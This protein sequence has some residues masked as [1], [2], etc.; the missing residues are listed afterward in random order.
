M[1]LIKNDP[2]V[3]RAL[4]AGRRA[5]R[6]DLRRRRAEATLPRAGQR[7]QAVAA[8]AGGD[9]VRPGRHV[10]PLQARELSQWRGARREGDGRR[11]PAATIRGRGL[12]AFTSH[13]NGMP[14]NWHNQGA[15]AGLYDNGDIHAVRILAMEPT[16][17]RKRRRTSGRLF[18]SHASERLRILGEIPRAQVRSGRRQAAARSRRQ[19]RHQLPGQD[20][21]RRGVHVSDARQARHGAEHGAD[22]A[23]ASARRDSRTTA[24]AA[25][26]TARSRRDFAL[27]R[28]REARLSR[29]GI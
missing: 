25:T 26:P 13:G 27:T 3:Q 8:P 11:S 4:A 21:G 16:T 22:L 9:A 29:S 5:L 12:D 20:S 7:R 15:D 6:A 1:L 17:D 18:H 14:L 2:E 10:E 28:G 19:S 23:S 24:A